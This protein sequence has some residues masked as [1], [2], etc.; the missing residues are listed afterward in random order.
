MVTK[1]LGL[2]LLPQAGVAIG[3]SMVAQTVMPE[4][5]A[6]I[7]TV[8]L[9]STVVYEVFGPVIAKNALIRAGEIDPSQI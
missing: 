1:Y 2:T 3:L 4:F 8:I 6:T 5:G 9:A 7:R